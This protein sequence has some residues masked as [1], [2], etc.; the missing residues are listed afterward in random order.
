MFG[1]QDDRSQLGIGE[2]D[3]EVTGIDRNYEAVWSIDES[4]TRCLDFFVLEMNLRVVKQQEAFLSVH[5]R[6][7]IVLGIVVCSSDNSCI[8]LSE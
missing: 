2:S 4:F 7:E 8:A 1:D 3:H 5:L 6:V